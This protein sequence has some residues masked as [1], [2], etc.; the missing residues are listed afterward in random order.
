MSDGSATQSVLTGQVTLVNSTPGP[1]TPSTKN[2]DPTHGK[3]LV[4]MDKDDWD[5]V[6]DTNLKSAYLCSKAAARSMLRAV[7]YHRK[8][9]GERV[10]Q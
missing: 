1:V 8:A 2:A 5:T 10:W 6:L 3:P 7:V 9:E 4:R